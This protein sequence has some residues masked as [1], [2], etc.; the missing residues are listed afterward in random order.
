MSRIVQPD[1][2]SIREAAEH[3]RSG[4]LVAFPTETVY[5]LG[6]DA[7]SN[8]AVRAVYAA[9][10][11]PSHNPLIVHVPDLAAA[12]ALVELD[13]RARRFAKKFW[14]G[15]LTLVL[16]ALPGASISQHATAGLS[17]IAIRVPAHPV[18]RA[19]LD[20][21]GRPIV[22]PSANPSG[23]ISPTTARHVADDFGDVLAMVLDGGACTIGL[24]STVI[25]LSDPGRVV[26]LRPGGLAREE[27][28]AVLGPLDRPGGDHAR[29]ASPGMLVSHYAPRVP[30]RLDSV[31]AEA[32]EALIAFGPDVPAGA[33]VVFNLSPSGNL[34]EAAA[35]LFAMLR[36]ADCSGALRIAVMPIP[37]KGLAEAIRDRL[38]RAA[39]PR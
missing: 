28:E 37:G 26:L 10:G 11:R 4:R 7:T 17:T 12:A 16:T 6:A 9:K 34:D 1:P 2:S 23:R 32:D 18:A 33:M 20:E 38:Q 31:W 13:D 35:N 14:P 8:A 3:L 27:L 39:A 36:M 25:D 21:A 29:P 24:E 30:V 5:G 15:P 19:L 22:A